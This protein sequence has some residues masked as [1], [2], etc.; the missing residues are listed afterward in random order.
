MSNETLNSRLVQGL[1]KALERGDITMMQ[2]VDM[3][4]TLSR[5]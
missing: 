1:D 5:G 4:Y 2:Y 3:F